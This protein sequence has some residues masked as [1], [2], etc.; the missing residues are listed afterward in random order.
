MAAFQYIEDYLEFI[1][2]YRDIN[3][4]KLSL[5]QTVPSPLS[6]AR[7][8]VN[9]VHSLASQ[10]SEKNT[11]YTDRQAEL[12][13]KIVNKYRRQL[14]QLPVPVTIPEN[15]DKFRMS[16]RTIDRTKRAYIANN[17]LILKFPYDAELITAVKTQARQGDAEGN[18]IVEEKIWQFGLTEC[19]I[20]W[21]CAISEKYN[22]EVDRSVTDLYI[23]ILDCEQQPYAIE[24][25]DSGK[26]YE[27]QNGDLNL[28]QYI[29]NHLG[30]FGYDNLL[31]LVD[32]SEPL[33]YTV[34]PT[35]M[36]K[37]RNDYQGQLKPTAMTCVENRHVVFKKD[38]AININEI[39]D[40][41]KA[42]DRLPIYV[43]A[44]GL[45]KESTDEVKYLKHQSVST[46]I[47]CLISE[48]NIMV[49]TR[50]QSWLNQAEKIFFIE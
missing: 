45:P 48:S 19:A 5:F 6:L 10:T 3:N 37:F 35:V 30:G 42:T 31:R 29:E 22:I 46:V 15:F 23:K 18:F 34:S 25:V 33:G 12:A 14:S 39:V 28:K 2:G 16:I 27:I 32:N 50:K 38:Q 36:A 44:M 40:Y 43:Y 7:Y 9:I 13:K 41:A 17:K 26:G 4:R 24:L 20:N 8:D 49:G 47:R 11:A 21:I 1:G